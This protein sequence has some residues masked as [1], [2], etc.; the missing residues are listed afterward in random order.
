[1]IRFVDLGT[2][3]GGYDDCPRQFAFYNTVVDL[4]LEFN[5]NQ[6]WENYRNLEVDIIT[7]R[8]GEIGPIENISQRLK[9]L[10]PNW[11]FKTERL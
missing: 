9:N 6:V 7:D 8:E 4:F 10:C 3:I 2:Q 11:V 5:G 1:M